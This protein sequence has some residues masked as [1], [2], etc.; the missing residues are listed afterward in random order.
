MWLGGRCPFDLTTTEDVA[1][2]TRQ[3]TLEA[4]LKELQQDNSSTSSSDGNASSGPAL[5]KQIAKPVMGLAYVWGGAGGRT[6][7]TQNLH[8]VGTDCSGFVSG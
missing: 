5:L 2:S 1:R 4:A 7:F 6:D 8:H 3:I